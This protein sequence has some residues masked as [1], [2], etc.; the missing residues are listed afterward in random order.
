M[1][2]TAEMYSYLKNEEFVGK[3][4]KDLPRDKIIISDKFWPAKLPGQDYITEDKLSEQGIRQS[5]EG[6]LKRLQTDYI[7][8]YTLHA[9]DEEHLEEVARVMG[10]LIKEGKIRG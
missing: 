1:F 7:D 6:S 4:L 10:L 8:L 9:M 5:L 2:D 3:A